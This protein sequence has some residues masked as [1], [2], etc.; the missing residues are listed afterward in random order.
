MNI[1]SYE[2]KFSQLAMTVADLIIL[3]LLYIVCC[4]PIF[5]IGAAQA[6]LFTGIR[7]LLDPED[8]SSVSKAFFRGFTNGFGKITLVNVILLTVLAGLTVLLAYLLTLM[9]A[10]GSRLSVILC[11]VAMSIVYIIH[12]VSSPFHATFDCTAGQLLRNS[13]FVAMAYPLRC[14]VSAALILIPL[15][16]LMIWPHIILGGLIAFA[17]LYYSVAYLMIFS[18]LKKPFNRLKENFYN[19]QKSADGESA[20]AS[21]IEE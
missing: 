12:S 18:L 15:A 9:F 16:I 7:V 21:M 17:A 20:A 11:I 3:N 8:D 5:T 1:F 6:G 13:V 2:S 19:A 14:I 10:G 4:I